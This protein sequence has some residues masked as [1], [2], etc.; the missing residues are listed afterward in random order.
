MGSSLPFTEFFSL[1]LFFF[2]ITYTPEKN[3]RK[4][5][6]F[7]VS[8]GNLFLSVGIKREKTLYSNSW[9][10]TEHTPKTL[11]IGWLIKGYRNQVK[12][13]ITI[14]YKLVPFNNKH[15]LRVTTTKSLKLMSGVFN[16][17]YL[18]HWQK[19]GHTTQMTVW[20]TMGLKGGRFLRKVVSRISYFLFYSHSHAERRISRE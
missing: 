1:F 19:N 16:L 10:H 6:H 7:H 20:L 5:S 12:T 15:L 17:Y 14:G 9:L 13:S 11:L 3:K 2:C 18:C 4:F 8:S